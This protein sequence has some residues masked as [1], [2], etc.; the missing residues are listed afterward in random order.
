MIDALEEG[1]EQ[2]KQ[3]AAHNEDCA[4]VETEFMQLIDAQMAL[5]EALDEEEAASE[6]SEDSSDEESDKSEKVKVEVNKAKEG[7]SVSEEEPSGMYKQAHGF[8]QRTW[9]AGKDLIIGT[10]VFRDAHDDHE[11]EELS[12]VREDAAPE[13]PMDKVFRHQGEVGATYEMEQIAIEFEENESERHDREERWRE[14][15]E[16]RV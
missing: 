6:T 13:S 15:R 9:K 7:A 1:E 5:M 12:P 16:E 10:S 11:T 2:E 8:M 3:R 4:Q 14:W